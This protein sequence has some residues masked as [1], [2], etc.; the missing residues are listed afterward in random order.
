VRDPAEGRRIE[1]ASS[2][3]FREVVVWNPPHREAIAIEPYTCCPTTF[4]LEERGFA[5]G[6]R[7]L[8]PGESDKL[9]MVISL[10]DDPS[11]RTRLRH[12]ARSTKAF[13]LVRR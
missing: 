1:I 9:R 5:A 8:E 10:V 3:G 11:A 12:S 6:L 7:V 13:G 2:G 4:D